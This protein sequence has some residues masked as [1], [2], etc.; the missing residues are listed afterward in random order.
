MLWNLLNFHEHISKA[1]CSTMGAASHERRCLGLDPWWLW[2][3]WSPNWHLGSEPR[4]SFGSENDFHLYR[5]YIYNTHTHI[6]MIWLYMIIYDYVCIFM[7]ILYVY[8][9]VLAGILLF[10]IF[11]DSRKG[12]QLAPT[13]RAD[14]SRNQAGTWSNSHPKTGLFSGH[15]NRMSYFAFVQSEE[16]QRLTKQAGIHKKGT[17]PGNGRCLSWPGQ[18]SVFSLPGA[19]SSSIWFLYKRFNPLW[20]VGSFYGNYLAVSHWS[21]DEH[22]WTFINLSI[23]FV[24]QWT[25]WP[26]LLGKSLLLFTNLW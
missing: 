1:S 17:K 25:Q 12:P 15:Q 3:R 26:S 24:L 19:G 20:I 21:S 14:R 11:P 13:I 22:R 7:F 23:Q 9:Y 4:R 2:L 8:V 10:L 6:Y 18:S 5:I 16:S